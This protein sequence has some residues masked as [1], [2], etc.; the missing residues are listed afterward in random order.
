[1]KVFVTYAIEHKADEAK[2]IDKL[3]AILQKDNQIDIFCHNVEADDENNNNPVDLL[4]RIKAADIFIGEMTISSQTL[5]FLLS[6]AINL[7]KPSLYL[8]PLGSSGLPGKIITHNP[9]RLL[10]VEEYNSD[11]LKAKL[12]KFIES[13]QNKLKSSRTTFISTRVIDE[14]INEKMN[15]TGLSKGEVI[16]KILEESI[17]RN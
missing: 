17:G 12:D 16:R 14:Y 2:R 8:Y 9:S 15:K 6:Y 1:M 5:G 4:Q 7:G 13:A 11:N 10:S 3:V